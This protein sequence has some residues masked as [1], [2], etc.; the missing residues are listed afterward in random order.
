MGKEKKGR[1][2]NPNQYPRLADP[3]SPAQ[4]PAFLFS[5]W[6]A[7]C[8]AHPGMNGD[9]CTWPVWSCEKGKRTHCGEQEGKDLEEG[10]RC[11][12]GEDSPFVSSARCGYSSQQ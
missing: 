3:S 6:S 5:V 12:R 2:R 4:G 9:H 11:L 7:C 8:L 10:S 1:I